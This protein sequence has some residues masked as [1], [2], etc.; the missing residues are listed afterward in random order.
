MKFLIHSNAPTCSVSWCT[1]TP[2]AKGL[3]HSHWSRSRKGLDLEAPWRGKDPNEVCSIEWCDRLSYA[4]ALCKEHYR[5]QREGRPLDTPWRRR[6]PRTTRGGYVM[7]YAP[8]HPRAT[9]AGEVAEHRLVMEQI[10]GRL[11][12]PFENVHHV[13]GIRDDNRPENLELWCKPQ[14]AGQRAEDLARWVADNYPDLVADL[15]AREVV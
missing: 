12:H 9:G 7:V 3:C 15:P 13:N 10:L 1:R 2:V 8:D 5:R 14:P 11:L 4:K 6:N